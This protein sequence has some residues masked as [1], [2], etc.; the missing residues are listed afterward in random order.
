MVKVSAAAAESDEFGELFA[1]AVD[2]GPDGMTGLVPAP[3][4]DVELV[5]DMINFAQEEQVLPSEGLA[6]SW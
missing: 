2:V 6:W 4:T 3:S 1:D 5:R